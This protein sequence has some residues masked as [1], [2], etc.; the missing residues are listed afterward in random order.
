MHETDMRL[1]RRV[2]VVVPVLCEK[3]IVQD[4]GNDPGKSSVRLS[5]VIPGSQVG[6]MLVGK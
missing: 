2:A 6:W 3:M 4:I 1:Q 5:K